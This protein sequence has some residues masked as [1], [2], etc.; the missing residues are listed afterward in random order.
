MYARKRTNQASSVNVIHKYVH[1][2]PLKGALTG[3][4]MQ[5][6]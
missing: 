1:K 3:G 4:L 5:L 6:T 2:T